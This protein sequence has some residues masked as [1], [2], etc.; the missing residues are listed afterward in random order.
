MD[1]VKAKV[2]P[3]LQT[4]YQVSFSITQEWVPIHT[5]PQL[6][7]GIEA[8]C[9]AILAS[10]YM[11]SDTELRYLA[12]R[13]YDSIPIVELMEGV[14]TM[15]ATRYP[16]SLPIRQIIDEA[17]R[18]HHIQTLPPVNLMEELQVN[19]NQLSDPHAHLNMVLNQNNGNPANPSQG[20]MN[21]IPNQV[22]QNQD[23][24]VLDDFQNFNQ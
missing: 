20:S 7:G 22:N 24:D 1:M 3:E 15:V 4:L 21:W 6:R 13:A 2:C 19:N 12:K 9:V 10:G 18:H 23:K 14:Q 11:V 17:Y 8:L 16:I 5:T